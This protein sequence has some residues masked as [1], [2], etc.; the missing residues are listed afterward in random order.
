LVESEKPEESEQDVMEVI[1]DKIEEMH[2]TVKE[3]A[4]EMK[5]VKTKFN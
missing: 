2:H 4:A 3:T 5:E 1:Q